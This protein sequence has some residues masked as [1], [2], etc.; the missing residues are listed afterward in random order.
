MRLLLFTCSNLYM[1]CLVQ[2]SITGCGVTTAVLLQPQITATGNFTHSS[3]HRTE[4]ANQW[5][6][7]VIL[8]RNR[9]SLSVQATSSGHI[10]FRWLKP[11]V[12]FFQSISSLQMSF[13]EIFKLDCS[14]EHAQNWKELLEFWLR[15]HYY[16]EM[17]CSK[18]P[19]I[20]VHSTHVYP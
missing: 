13:T 17:G 19:S 8:C 18:S 20:Q 14:N 12:Y 11:T 2:L 10:G 9:S 16:W 15:C 5:L 4:C 1:S 3:P 7:N 6:L